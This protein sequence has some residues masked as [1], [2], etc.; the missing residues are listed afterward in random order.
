[1]VCQKTKEKASMFCHKS[2]YNVTFKTEEVY[3]CVKK[4]MRRKRQSEKWPWK[5]KGRSRA[6]AF[7]FPSLGNIVATSAVE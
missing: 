3:I 4:L 2:H 6:L 1:M 5:Q 7:L